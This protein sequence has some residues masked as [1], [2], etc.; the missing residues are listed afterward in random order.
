MTARRWESFAVAL[1]LEMGAWPSSDWTGA[2]RSTIFHLPTNER[3]L[4][5]TLELY[6]TGRCTPPRAPH[7]EFI[8]EPRWRSYSPPDVLTRALRDALAA[9]PAWATPS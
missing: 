4:Q 3:V 9:R 1:L 6:H 7:G 5:N 8:D 2:A